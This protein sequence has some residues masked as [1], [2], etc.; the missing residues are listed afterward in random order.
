MYVGLGI[1]VI[2]CAVI[3]IIVSSP[4]MLIAAIAIKLTSKGPLIFA[5]ERIGLHNKPFK[6][7]KFRTMYTKEELGDKYEGMDWT[8]KDDPR[9]TKCGKVMRR[10]NLDELPQ[11]FNIIIGDMSFV[12]PRPERVEHVEK[13]EKELPQ[14]K[15]RHVVK[16]GLTGYAQVYGKYSTD[17]YSKLCM[18]LFYISRQSL[19]LDL[20][21]IFRTL[22]IPF[23]REKSS[24]IE[25]ETE[26][27]HA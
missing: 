17:P 24:G 25:D 26:K 2:I 20:K 12:G 5:Q 15:Y 22:S 6:V 23:I 16:G 19:S 8:T 3:G 18:D 10:F 11:L 9:V 1:F 4:V 21:L 14:F 13:Y 7:Y 27:P